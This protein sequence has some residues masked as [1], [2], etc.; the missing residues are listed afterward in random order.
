M[1]WRINTGRSSACYNIII[2]SITG[3]NHPQATL[4]PDQ[5]S[6]NLTIKLVTIIATV[7]AVAAAAASAELQERQ[8]LV[9]GRE[10][11]CIP[12]YILIC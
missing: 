1:I 5:Y 4:S 12:A 2:N 6:S 10:Y 9:N 11:T 7:I 8:C 3:S